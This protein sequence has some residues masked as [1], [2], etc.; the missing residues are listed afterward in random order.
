MNFSELTTLRVGGPA[1]A[2]VEATTRDEVV[3]TALRFWAEPADWMI[4]GGGSNLVVADDGFDGNVLRIA[5]RGID[6]A[7]DGVPRIRVEAGEEC[8]RRSRDQPDREEGRPEVARVQLAAMIDLAGQLEDP[9]ADGDAGADGHLLG[10]ADE[11][12]RTA[13]PLGRD[14]RVDDRV[15]PGELQR[16]EAAADQEHRDDDRGRRCGREQPAGGDEGGRDDGVPDEDL[17]EAEP[18]EDA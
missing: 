4:L 12:R 3:E 13:H 2:L 8:H 1:A 6:R 9:R 11:A 7:T 17:T 18:P 15:E 16:P 10:D 14:V 5:N